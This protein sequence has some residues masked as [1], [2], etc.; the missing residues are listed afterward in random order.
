MNPYLPVLIVLLLG[1]GLGGILSGLAHFAG[2]RKPNRIKSE[3]YECGVPIVGERDKMSVKFYLT[4]ILFILFDIETVFLYLWAMTFREL[5]WFGIGEIVVFL[6][7]LFAGY[8]Y[9]VKR[10]ALEW[11]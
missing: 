6:A 3:P 9:V 8:V 5:G 7:V 2:P 10:G 1:V 4:A 11:D